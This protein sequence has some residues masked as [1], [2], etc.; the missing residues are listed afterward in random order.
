ML[1]L[2]GTMQAQIVTMDD[3][4][5]FRTPGDLG[6]WGRIPTHNV[7]YDQYNAIAPLGEGVLLLTALGGAYL[8]GGRRRGGRRLTEAHTTKKHKN[9]YNNTYKNTTTK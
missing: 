4:E 2:A 3:E 8:L 5:N 9:T 7:D 1:M 6:D